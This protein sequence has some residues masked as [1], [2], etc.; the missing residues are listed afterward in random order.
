VPRGK[1]AYADFTAAGGSCVASPA[2]QIACMATQIL[3][4]RPGFMHI[5]AGAVLPMAARTI[6]LDPAVIASPAIT[7]TV[8]LLIYL[9][10][11][12]GI[13]NL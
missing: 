7:T 3:I 1:C 8:G 10:P 2:F 12:R 13:L 9:N 6:K 5:N 4:L 11:A